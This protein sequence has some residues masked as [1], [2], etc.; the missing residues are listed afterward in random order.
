MKIKSII[1][2]LFISSAFLLMSASCNRY[3]RQLKSFEK[4]VTKLEQNYQH[5][6]PQKLMKSIRQCENQIMKLD[7]HKDK[8]TLQQKQECLTQKV[9]Y[10]K[11]LVQ[12][13][14]H[15]MTVDWGYEVVEDIR[16]FINKCLSEL[17]KL[18]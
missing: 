1:A 4:S 14:V 16:Q 8:L 13:K 7:S 2:L 15:L 11:L 6:S 9:L 17:D 18:F 5:Y 12:I 10:T 3:D